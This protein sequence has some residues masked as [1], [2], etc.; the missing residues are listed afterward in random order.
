MEVEMKADWKRQQTLE[1]QF[2]LYTTIQFVK[3]T[4]WEIETEE[5]KG[6]ENREGGREK[7][8]KS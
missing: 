6:K 1:K 4:I 8:R 7:E 2:T 3:N 5:R